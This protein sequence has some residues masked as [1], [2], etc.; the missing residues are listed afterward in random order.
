MAIEEEM[1]SEIKKLENEIDVLDKELEKLHGRILQIIALRRKK[2]KEMKIL[3]RQFEPESEEEFQTTL[4]R[5]MK[6]KG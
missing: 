2:E 5:L 4:A 1:R 3:K 6:E